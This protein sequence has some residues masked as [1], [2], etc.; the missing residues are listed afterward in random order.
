MSAVPNATATGVTVPP[1]SLAGGLPKVPALDNTFGAVL[2]GTYVA[3][4][5]YG[6]TLHQA[7]RY[8]CT[9][10]DDGRALKSLVAFIVVLD[11]VTSV[12]SM[13]ICYYHLVTSYFKPLALHIGDWTLNLFP[14][15]SGI[16]MISSQSFFARRVW[17]VGGRVSKLLVLF[18]A[19]LCIAELGYFI[20]ASTEAEIVITFEGFRSHIWLVSTGTTLATAVDTLLTIMLIILLHRSRTGIKHTDN[21]IDTLILYSVNT[22]LMT[23]ILNLLSLLFAY[24]RPADLIYIGFA[25]PGTKMYATTLLAA[26]NSRQHAENTPGVLHDRHLFGR[27]GNAT[28]IVN[29]ASKA[30]VHPQLR[31]G[32]TVEETDSTSIIELKAPAH[33]DAKHRYEESEDRVSVRYNASGDLSV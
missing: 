33:S 32:R 14:V 31:P 19:V 6:V 4:I 9:Y 25:I 3:L 17:L 7:H 1:N 23:G 5:L 2:L 30:A 12:L 18:S 16:V 27:G 29:H 11:T 15:I 22:G 21:M 24:I 13:H 10:P 20:A 26:L 8:Y 28:L